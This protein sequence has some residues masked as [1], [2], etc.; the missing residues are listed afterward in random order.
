[1]SGWLGQN[2]PLLLPLIIALAAHGLFVRLHVVACPTKVLLGTVTCC[3][4]TRLLP[5]QAALSGGQ[6]Q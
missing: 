3:K 4:F 1:M 6:T 2:E 5:M